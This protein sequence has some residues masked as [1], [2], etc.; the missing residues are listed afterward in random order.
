MSGQN[1][2]KKNLHSCQDC[3][4]KYIMTGFEVFTING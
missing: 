1:L 4:Q 2:L 3:L